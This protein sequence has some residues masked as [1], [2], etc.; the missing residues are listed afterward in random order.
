MKVALVHD[1]LNTYGGAERVLWSMHKVFPDAPIFTTF[2]DPTKLPAEF[3]HD[4]VVPSPLANH[5]LAK[6]SSKVFS[7]SLPLV[8]E[9]LDLDEFDVVI[10]ST[11]SFAK[12]VITNSRQFHLCYCHTPPR[13]LY[14]YEGESTKRSRWYLK[15]WL[16][17]VDSYL[18]VWDY[19]ASLRVDVFLANSQNTASRIK[20]FYQRESII[21]YPPVATIPRNSNNSS[22][23]EGFFL[24]VSRLVPY[25]HVELAIEASNRLGFNLKVVGQ[26]SEFNRLAALAGS[27]VELL[28]FVSEDELGLLYQQCKG[29]IYTPRDEDFGLIPIEAMAWGKPVIAHNSGGVQE[30]IQDDVTGILFDEYTVDGLIGAIQRFEEVTFDPNVLYEHTQKFSEERFRESL[31][32]VV[33]DTLQGVS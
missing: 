5:P 2:Y 9:S 27:T 26:G 4:R 15:P 21:L 14:K 25:K 24:V 19:A 30:T 12:G 17:L 6:I 18:R 1:F 8:F 22:V 23:G 32:Q 20:K 3:P 29:V 16:S 28:G 31:L 10:S 13:F 33:H 11:A 7:L